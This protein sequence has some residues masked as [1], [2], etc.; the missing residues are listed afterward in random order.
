MKDGR[1]EFCLSSPSPQFSSLVLLSF[2]P[3]TF[4]FPPVLTFV[5]YG[6]GSSARVDQTM[7]GLHTVWH[8]LLLYVL[9]CIIAGFI[10]HFMD[11]LHP[12]D[13]FNYNSLDK[14]LKI[15]IF[16]VDLFFLLMLKV[17]IYLFRIFLTFRAPNQG[18]SKFAH[19]LLLAIQELSPP[20]PLSRHRHPLLI[21]VSDIIQLDQLISL[22]LSGFRPA[23]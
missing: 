9:I 23:Q 11:S 8:L 19:A 17:N 20:S 7:T 14:F 13:L 3:A 16:L 1:E 21:S 4:L 22:H 5:E 10:I 6:V 2:L 15:N 12:S 18:E